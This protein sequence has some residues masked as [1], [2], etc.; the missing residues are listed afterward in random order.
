MFQMRVIRG[1][2]VTVKL[3]AALRANSVGMS[4]K[5]VIVKATAE[6]TISAVNK[7][8]CA[9]VLNLPLDRLGKEYYTINWWE[10]HAVSL[11]KVGSP[12]F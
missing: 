6:V 7:G 3:P 1:Q 8:S 12:V 5:A 9:A 2:G 4:D 10:P 11:G